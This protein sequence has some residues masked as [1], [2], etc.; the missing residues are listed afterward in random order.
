[1]EIIYDKELGGWRIIYT[2]NEF[3]KKEMWG[4]PVNNKVYESW[5]DAMHDLDKWAS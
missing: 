4:K 5:L 1:M 2:P 3:L